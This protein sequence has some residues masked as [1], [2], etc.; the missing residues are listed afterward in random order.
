VAVA[1]LLAGSVAV[2][3]ERSDDGSTRLDVDEDG[4]PL[5]DFDVG[6]L[7]PLGP[8]DGKDSIQLPL[9]ADP[10]TGLHDGDRVAVS[11]P[12][13]EPGE[14][15]GIV[16][17]AKEAGGDSPE[18]RGGIDGCYVGGVQ[19]ADADAEGVASGSIS[20][21]R[22]LTTPM[23]GTVD[24]A[25]EANRCIVAMGALSNY[26]RSGGHGIEF[27][28]DVAP[29]VLPTLTVTPAE[30]LADGDVVHVV[31][32]G[33]TPRSFVSLMVC[34]SDP[35]ACWETGGSSEDVP[36]SGV[37]DQGYMGMA[38]DGDGHLEADVP[39]WR[40]LP[41]NEPGTYVDCAVSRCSLRLSGDMAPPT[42]PL[43]FTLDDAKPA[44]PALSVV[45]ADGLAPGD[46]VVVR[47]KGFAPGGPL[48]VSMCARPAGG[49]AAMGYLACG[50]ANDSEVRAE[51]DG[52][53]ALQL[54]VPDLGSLGG[55]VEDCPTDGG[56]ATTTACADECVGGPMGEPLPIRC[57]GIDT[58][59]YITADVYQGGVGPRPP[60]F[61]P[62]PVEVTFR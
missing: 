4:E 59:C 27:A 13:F 44:S 60:I 31:A 20:V 55:Y 45:P 24:C 23:T 46:K 35:A 61:P 1:V 2:L 43:R 16:Q 38:V 56:C 51:D 10:A 42:V 34:S 28:T 9:T 5:P 21:Q 26:D 49:D 36:Y 40:F 39:V 57:D 48:M 50:S 25:A 22:V 11:S 7:R 18:T 32:D 47:G 19:Y 33:L 54:E 6:V 53:F 30:G 41:S 8:H 3:N 14:R 37:D 17:C 12:G 15:V 62:S 29:I 58:E 52:T